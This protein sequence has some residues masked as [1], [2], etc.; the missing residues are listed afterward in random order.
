[1]VKNKKVQHLKTIE[2]PM[3]STLIRHGTYLLT[4]W[5][6]SMA[7]IMLKNDFTPVL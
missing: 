4:Y 3:L 6:T 1:M 7:V 2:I 5:K